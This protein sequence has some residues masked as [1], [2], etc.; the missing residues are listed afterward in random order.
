MEAVVLKTECAGPIHFCVDSRLMLPPDTKAASD[1]HIPERELQNQTV[2]LLT[3]RHS[4]PFRKHCLKMGVVV[5]DRNPSTQ[6]AKEKD[7]R[8]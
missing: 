7:R 6:E 5:R 3:S 2:M 8:A 1:L 4:L